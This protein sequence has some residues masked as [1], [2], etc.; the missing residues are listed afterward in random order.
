MAVVDPSAG[1]WL[2]DY[3]VQFLVGPS[4]TGP[5]EQFIDERCVFFDLPNPDDNKLEY[6]EIHNEFKQLVDSLIAAALVDVDVTPEAFAAAFEA[7]AAI[8]PRLETIA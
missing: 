8:D 4:W 2:T 5:I 1:S 7:N 6:T 3:V